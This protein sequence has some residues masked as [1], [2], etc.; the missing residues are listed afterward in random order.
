MVI[1]LLLCTSCDVV[2]RFGKQRFLSAPLP[3]S[4]PHSPWGSS[5]WPAK[6]PHGVGGVLNG[7]AAATIIPR[8]K[9]T[10]CQRMLFGKTIVRLSTPSNVWFMK[11]SLP[12]HKRQRPPKMRSSK[13]WES[14]NFSSQSSD[15]IFLSS[16]YLF[17]KEGKWL[18][19]GL[20]STFLSRIL[21]EYCNSLSGGS[22]PLSHS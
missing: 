21:R 1:S 16:K 6:L 2:K 4:L 12:S 17:K 7:K 5:L 14:A 8:S 22:C 18:D 19:R 9:T 10:D 13:V 3:Y 11:S 20:I 15:W